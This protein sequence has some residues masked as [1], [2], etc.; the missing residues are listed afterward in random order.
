MKLLGFLG[1]LLFTVFPI[2][3]VLTAS[4]I[5]DRLGIRINEGSPPVYEILGINI[6]PYLYDMFVAGF[7]IFYTAP[8]GL[9]LMIAYS[10]WWHLSN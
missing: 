6:G 5:S 9:V 7:F 10:I 1:I 4:F 3:S 8:I 2:I